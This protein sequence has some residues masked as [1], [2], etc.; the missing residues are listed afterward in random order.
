MR[1]VDQEPDDRQQEGIPPRG[2]ILTRGCLRATY[3]EKDPALSK[4]Y[5]PYYGHKNPRP[6]E[7][8]AAFDSAH[9]Y[10]LK[11]GKDTIYHDGEHPSHMILPVIPR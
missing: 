7:P 6:I 5:R 11:V 1:L 9:H 8:G 4:P 2:K 10:G 3:R